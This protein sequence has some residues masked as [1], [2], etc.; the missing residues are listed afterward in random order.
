MPNP[1]RLNRRASRRRRFRNVRSG[2]RFEHLEARRLLVV[3]PYAALTP[4]NEDYFPFVGNF[5]V[6]TST[7]LATGTLVA[8][9]L[10]LTAAH[11]ADIGN[12][13]FQIGGQSAQVTKSYIS[14]DWFATSGANPSGSDIAFVQLS[15]PISG[16]TPVPI[17]SNL[18]LFQSLGWGNPSV[19]VSGYAYSF[20][21]SIV[22]GYGLTGAG[23]NDAGIKRA[24]YV[25]LEFAQWGEPAPN[26]FDDLYGYGANIV[27]G[28]VYGFDGVIPY[29]ALS[30]ID[31]G[32]SGGQGQR[33]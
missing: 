11:V 4:A 30:L 12:L 29:T 9:D 27:N 8:P 13:S 5:S 21:N 17:A 28:N 32:D 31:H 6:G 1:F 10:V 33:A 25:Q 18:D 2:L 22:V 24:G 15:Q 7:P 20:M 26:V 14:P 23:M 16:I 3:H 19:P